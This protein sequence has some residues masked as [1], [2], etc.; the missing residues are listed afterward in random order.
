MYVPWFS[1][2]ET[3]K[4]VLQIVNLSPDESVLEKI[5]EVHPMRQIA[6]MSV[7]Q[8]LVFGFMLLSFWLINLGLGH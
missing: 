7:V 3:E 8:V 1:K 4:K 5:E 6:V 2:P